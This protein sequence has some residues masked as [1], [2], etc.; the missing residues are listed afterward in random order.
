MENRKPTVVKHLLQSI[1]LIRIRRFL[2]DN[3]ITCTDPPSFNVIWPYICNSGKIVLGIRCHF[4]S[5]R[6]QQRITVKDSAVLRIGDCC[7]MNDGVSIFAQ[8]SVIIGANT[9]IGDMVQRLV[10]VSSG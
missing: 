4:R 3:N 7:F 5:P 8:N 9:L 6:L 10:A 2:A 1:K